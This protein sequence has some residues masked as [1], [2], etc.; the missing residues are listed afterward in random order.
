MNKTNSFSVVSYNIYF[1][2]YPA[3]G[4]K[5]TNPDRIS[6]IAKQLLQDQFSIIAGCVEK[7]SEYSQGSH[8]TPKR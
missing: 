1:D 2:G 7:F 6:L 4:N 5:P 3:S 8:L